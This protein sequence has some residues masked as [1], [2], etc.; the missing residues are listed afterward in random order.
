MSHPEV[1]KL[2]HENLD[3][4]LKQKS[5]VLI[6][7]KSDCD[8]CNQWETDLNDAFANEDLGDLP[9]GKLNLDQRKLGN[10]KRE[11]P[12]LQEVNDLP[13]NA[14]YRDGDLVKS[15]AGGGISRLKPRLERLG[16]M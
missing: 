5:F 13:F 1:L 4:F 14:I 10:F 11:N 2:D 9:V 16:L 8:A 6:L 7:G 15:F 12:W 3:E